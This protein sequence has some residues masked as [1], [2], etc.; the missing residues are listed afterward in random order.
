MQWTLS[1]DRAVDAK[2]DVKVLD[3]YRW[4]T[5][6]PEA[7]FRRVTGTAGFPDGLKA[8]VKDGSL[9]YFCNTFVTYTLRGVHTSLNVIWDWEAPAG[10]GDTHF[11]VYRGTKARIEAR[12]TKADGYK[13]EVYIVPNRAADAPAILAAARSRVA[14]VAA[15]WPG[16]GAE[17]KGAEIKL[18]HS[19]RAAR[20]ARGALRPGDGA[21]P[22]LPARS[23]QAAGLGAAQHAG[24]VHGDDGRHGDEPQR[25]GEGRPAARAALSAPGRLTGAAGR[26]AGGVG[27]VRAPALPVRQVVTAACAAFVETPWG[28]SDHGA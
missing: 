21:L 26:P 20:R 18:V 11:A 14:A 3:A 22:E 6:I 1:P 17:M 28:G 8:R 5:M 24:E 10:G 19:R 16:V 2:A 15:E 23:Q 4:P 12:Q 13:P 25:P 27:P 9:E 7:D